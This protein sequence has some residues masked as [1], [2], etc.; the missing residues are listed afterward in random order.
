MKSFQIF[1]PG[2][3]T[4]SSGQVIEFTEDMLKAAVAAYDPALHEAPI[5]VGHPVTNGPAYGWVKSLAFDESGAIVADPQQ[6]DADFAE[7]VQA[8][9]FKKR[10]A[11][12]YLPDS[13]VNP[14]PGTLYLRHVGFLGAQAPAL[15]GLKEVEF[16]EGDGIV[17]FSDV[18][19]ITMLV[20]NFARRMRE[21][22]IAKEGIEQ[23]DNVIPD[24]LVAGLEDE[25]RNPTPDP[26]PASAMPAFSEE[27]PMKIEELQAQ[28]ASLTAENA[29]L[30]ANQ[31][32]ADF[33]ERETALQA[34]E[35]AVAAAEA[36][37]DRAT[38][39]AR[40]DAVVKA[41]KLLPAKRK[42][43][44]D[45]AMTLGNGEAV[46]DFGEGDKAEKVTQREAYLRELEA[47]PKV[48]D[49]SERAP[50][51]GGAPDDKATDP[52]AIAEKAR[53]L[54][55]NRQAEGKTMSYTEAVA[56]VMAADSAA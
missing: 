26:Q 34:R 35:A 13:P 10:S 32:P 25:A 4:S 14:K 6:I 20:A 55:K 28:V 17:E 38:V 16:K 47:A 30:K 56:E 37:A 11:S 33:G 23:A 12:W 18:P 54:V 24:Y 31:K 5:V 7:M 45:F 52:A 43:V 19:Y 44:A 36:R 1:K 46:I 21:W 42:S 49:Y 9:R 22:F 8:G 39:E 15:K 29:T 2:K 3:H 50:G 41:G 48:V 40:I 53:D 27:D 51:A